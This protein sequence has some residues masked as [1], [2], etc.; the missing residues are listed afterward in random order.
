MPRVVLEAHKKSVRRMLDFFNSLGMCTPLSTA[1]FLYAT[2][3]KEDQCREAY[4]MEQPMYKPYDSSLKKL[5]RSNPQA[6]VS[7]ALKNARYIHERAYHL[8]HWRQEVDGLFDV[9]AE[10][11]NILTGMV[12]QEL[13]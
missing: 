1:R 8:E 4:S 13:P 12:K 9:E 7:L 3:W 11:K 6:F 2:L 10:G 5:I